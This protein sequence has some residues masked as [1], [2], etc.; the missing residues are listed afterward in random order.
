M[1]IPFLDLNFPLKK[2]TYY[3]K[4]LH[5]LGWIK[6]RVENLIR[7]ALLAAVFLVYTHLDRD[8]NEHA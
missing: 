5:P 6:I 8:L 3:E 1:S 4:G 2:V 7:S